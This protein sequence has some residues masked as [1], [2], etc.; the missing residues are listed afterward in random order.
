MAM[1]RLPMR[2]WIGLSTAAM[3]ALLWAGIG[4]SAFFHFSALRPWGSVY[5]GE[6]VVDLDFEH[7]D[8][9]DPQS[10]RVRYGRNSSVRLQ[11]RVTTKI[12]PV[13]YNVMPDTDTDGLP[14]PLSL[15]QPTPV[16]TSIPGLLWIQRD[17]WATI[18][19]F[20]PW[21]L[22]VAAS[23]AGTPLVISG[24]RRRPAGGLCS[25]CGYDRASLP[26]ATPCPE[27][28]TAKST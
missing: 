3:A 28:G 11:W 9:M 6:G 23:L 2:F 18:V 8:P 19:K 17:S 21:P 13:S 7:S 16:T 4:A 26:A 20:V 10:H 15:Q 24:W 22:A 14:S 27:C 5:V 12:I 1:R 25:R